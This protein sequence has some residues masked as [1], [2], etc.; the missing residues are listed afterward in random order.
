M[1]PCFKVYVKLDDLNLFYT[2]CNMKLH[3]VDKLD[4]KSFQKSWSWEIFFNEVLYE[5][6]LSLARHEE[7]LSDFISESLDYSLLSFEDDIYQ[8]LLCC[9][10]S[11]KTSNSVF[12]KKILKLFDL[13]EEDAFVA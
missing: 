10:S 8:L 1:G 7:L 2:E 13:N 3:S 6:T 11:D 12:I 4:V 5:I 9:S